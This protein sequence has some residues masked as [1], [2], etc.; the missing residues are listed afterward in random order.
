MASVEKQL[1]GTE[2]IVALRG[3]GVHSRICGLSANDLETAFL[4]AGADFFLLK[5]FPVGNDSLLRELDRIL[6]G[7]RNWNPRSVAVQAHESEKAPD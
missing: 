2:T 6:F 4:N 1:L 5:P 7:E 3:K